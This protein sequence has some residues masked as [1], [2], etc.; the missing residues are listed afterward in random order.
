MG[1][2]STDESDSSEIEIPYLNSLKPFEFKPKTNI[3]DINN[4]SSDDQEECNEDK[5]K[6]IG[7]REWCV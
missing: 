1:K 4:S 6:Q 5:V 2:N 7:N 3:G